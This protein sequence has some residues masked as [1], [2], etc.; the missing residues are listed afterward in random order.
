LLV[1]ASQGEAAQRKLKVGPRRPCELSSEAVPAAE[2][3]AASLRELSERE[4][5]LGKDE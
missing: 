5:G 1:V 4:T 3:G 2:R